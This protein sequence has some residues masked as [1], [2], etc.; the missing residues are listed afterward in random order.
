MPLIYFYTQQGFLKIK[1]S[2]TANA[3]RVF[4]L[5]FLINYY[6]NKLVKIRQSEPVS[7]L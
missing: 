4:E 2:I 7:Y 5:M 3:A 6:E 1:L